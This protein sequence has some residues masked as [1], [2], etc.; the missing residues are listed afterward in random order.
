MYCYH[1][2]PQEIISDQGPQFVCN[3]FT[4]LHQAFGVHLSPSTVFHQRTNGSAERAIKKIAQVLRAYVNS[5]QTNW[6]SQ[7][8]RV[9]LTTVRPR[10]APRFA[11]APHENFRHN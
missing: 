8:W 1:G 11:L 7:L 5:K 10:F 9:V 3:Y 2:I 6:V 4:E